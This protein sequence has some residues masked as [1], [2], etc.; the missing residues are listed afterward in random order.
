[1]TFTDTV[2]KLDNGEWV[3]TTRT[4]YNQIT[5]GFGCHTLIKSETNGRLFIKWK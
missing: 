1:M 2:R 4:I 5:L 3:E